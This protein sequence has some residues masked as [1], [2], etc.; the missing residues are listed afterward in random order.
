MSGREPYLGTAMAPTIPA[1]S[2]SR[3]YWPLALLWLL[4]VLPLTYLAVAMLE[5][6]FHDLRLSGAEASFPLLTQWYQTL[7]TP[8]L[9]GLTAIP[10]VLALVLAPVRAHL[11]AV[12][13]LGLALVASLYIAFGGMIAAH[14]AYVKMCI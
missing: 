1:R 14:V 12:C 13:A 10:A 5:G 9:Y 2:W 6:T 8:G 3:T 11:F 4:V 7:G